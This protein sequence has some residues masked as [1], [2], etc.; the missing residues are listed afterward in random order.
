MKLQTA[1]DAF[2]L[3]QTIRGNSP[4]TVSG[5]RSILGYFRSF[6][7]DVNVEE[8][9]LDLLRSYYFHLHSSGLADTLGIPLV[10]SPLSKYESCV[11]I[12]D[13]LEAE[14]K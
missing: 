6:S 13:F 3:E 1:I 10:S 11:R 2:L 12:H 8:I 7:G 5:Y 14:K 4:M 9:D